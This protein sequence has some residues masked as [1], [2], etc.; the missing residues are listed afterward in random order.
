[1]WSRE[2]SAEE[3]SQLYHAGR[4]GTMRGRRQLVDVT[5]EQES[6][7]LQTLLDEIKE[8]KAK[9]ADLERRLETKYADLERRLDAI[10]L[11]NANKM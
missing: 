2:L 10:E 1:M 7:S 9:N 11:A 4:L 8:L 3:I 6:P 5:D